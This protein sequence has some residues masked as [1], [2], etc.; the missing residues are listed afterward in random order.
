M[1]TTDSRDQKFTQPQK[2]VSLFPGKAYPYYAQFCRFMLKMAT[3]HFLIS[4]VAD[5]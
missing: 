5:I 1:T 2:A 4:D 3:V